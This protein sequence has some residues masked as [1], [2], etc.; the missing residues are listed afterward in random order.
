MN[1]SG[2][3]RHN[4]E[5]ELE[6]VGDDLLLYSPRNEIIFALNQTS[7]LIWNLCD[8]SRTIAEI[9]RLLCDAYPEAAINIPAQ[10]QETILKLVDS[11][12]LQ[13]VGEE[14]GGAGSGPVRE[15]EDRS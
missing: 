2:R 15:A 6:S 14:T 12:A 11:Q 9:L 5:M 3:L 10:A 4:P 13:W 8:G 1:L 7:A